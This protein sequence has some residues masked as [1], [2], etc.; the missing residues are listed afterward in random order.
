MDATNAS[1][2]GDGMGERGRSSIGRAVAGPAPSSRPMPGD[3]REGREVMSSRPM[4]GPAPS[5]GADAS[6]LVAEARQLDA[7]ARDHKRRS[8][9]HRRLA[10]EARTRQAEVEAQCRRL[11]IEVT[12]SNGKGDEPWPRQENRSSI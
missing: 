4:A 6:Q 5:D 10:R 9:M 2:P 1:R 11:G 3:G 7:T 12:Y 8:G